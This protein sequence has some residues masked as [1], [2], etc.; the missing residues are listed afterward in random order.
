M[1]SV[2]EKETVLLLVA[3]MLPQSMPLAI[4][5]GLLASM[6]SQGTA[7][8]IVFEAVVQATETVIAQRQVQS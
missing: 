5:Q 3:E 1:M 8:S 6:R 4:R 7:A 2:S